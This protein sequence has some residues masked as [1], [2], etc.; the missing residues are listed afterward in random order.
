VYDQE[1]K[2]IFSIYLPPKEQV[3]E[4]V[5][6]KTDKFDIKKINNDKL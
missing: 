3:Q 5:M 1:N 6:H 4:P 2:K